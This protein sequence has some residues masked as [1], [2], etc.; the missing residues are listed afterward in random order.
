MTFSIFATL[1][2]V[3]CTRVHVSDILDSKVSN[4]N[5]NNDQTFTENYYF[6]EIYMLN[7]CIM[8][9]SCLNINKLYSR[10]WERVNLFVMQ[11]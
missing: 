6:I 3:S 4:L 9:I 2:A 11:E 10:Y 5:G 1:R 8:L 7:I